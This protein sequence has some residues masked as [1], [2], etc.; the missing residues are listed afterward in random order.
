M[1]N[2][3][4]IRDVFAAG[5]HH[6]SPLKWHMVLVTTKD[7]LMAKRHFPADRWA[8]ASPQPF[9]LL[10]ALCLAILIHLLFFLALSLNASR[11][12]EPKLKIMHVELVPVLTLQ[13]AADP[14]EAAKIAESAASVAQTPKAPDVEPAVDSAEIRAQAQREE[15]D[16][17]LLEQQHQREAQ[18]RRAQQEPEEG[19]LSPEEIRRAAAGLETGRE[20]NA[21][22]VPCIEG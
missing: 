2:S 6:A 15:R 10:V 14:M 9:R 21:R 8:F 16:R 3:S 22:R 12:L 11:R 18:Q 13:S 7:Q 17:L 1:I 19:C 5:S 4:T 20:Q